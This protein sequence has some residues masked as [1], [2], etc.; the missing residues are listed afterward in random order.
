VAIVV[1]YR[2]AGVIKII[3]AIQRA[4]EKVIQ[5]VGRR[6]KGT[7]SPADVEQALAV[8]RQTIQDAGIA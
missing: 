3:T 5:A 6:T 4:A 8:L 2:E 1:P 7:G